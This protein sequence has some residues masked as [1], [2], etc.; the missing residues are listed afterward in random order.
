[1]HLLFPELMKSERYMDT[2]QENA[3][4]IFNLYSS[5]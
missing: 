2:R 4:V 1:M 5:A 3:D